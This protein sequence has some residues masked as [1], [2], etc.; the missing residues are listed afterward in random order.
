[1]IESNLLKSHHYYI[2]IF[3]V[4]NILNC[5]KICSL[6]KG[7]NYVQ[8][9]SDPTFELYHLQKE[10]SGLYGSA[11]V[12]KNNFSKYIDRSPYYWYDFFFGKFLIRE[13]DF[14]FFCYPYKSLQGILEKEFGE[15]F[16]SKDNFVTVDLDI[17]I[18]YFRSK[19]SILVKDLN[20]NDVEV[21]LINYSANIV[22]DDEA[23]S[24]KL[25]GKDP[26]GSKVFDFLYNHDTII[27][28]TSSLK[29]NAFNIKTESEINFRCDYHNNVRFWLPVNEIK[30]YKISCGNAL[31]M[32]KPT[33]SFL[34][35][36][37]SLG[38]RQVL[39]SYSV[40][41]DE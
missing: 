36:I 40:I 27:I 23:D 39:S 8:I 26:V 13:E 33:F 25:I 14:F 29:L 6:I 24:L 22:E 4:K 21:N 10:V 3:K 18:D 9:E 2:L 37:N 19:K 15:I 31:S 12:L 20:N 28:K 5:D 38:F 7:L 1:M 17:L 11:E 30:D 41:D 32:L 35:N 16:E 34:E